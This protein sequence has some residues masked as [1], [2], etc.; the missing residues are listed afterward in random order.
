MPIRPSDRHR[1]PKDWTAIRARI[2]ER[3]GNR[4]EFC[5]LEN[6]VIGRRR[7]D[8]SFERWDGIGTAHASLDRIRLARIVLTIAHLDHTPENNAESNLRALCQ[9]CHLLHDREQH[10]RNARENRVRRLD[11][12]R[13]LLS[14]MEVQGNDRR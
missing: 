5:G 8:G 13:P 11:A 12:A 6:G 3:A 10:I 4:C 9:R 14:I 1:Y 2:L 7:P